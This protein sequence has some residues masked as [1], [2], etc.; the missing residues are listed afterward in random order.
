MKQIKI[1]LGKLLLR[2]AIGSLF[3]LHG[4]HK[5]YTVLVELKVPWQKMDLLKCC[6]SDVLLVK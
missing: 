2:I 5:I 4:I 3:L 1:D 6:G